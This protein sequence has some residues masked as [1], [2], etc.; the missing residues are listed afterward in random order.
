M[1]QKANSLDQRTFDKLSRLYI[2]ALS[3]IA[4]SVIISQ[5]FVRQHLKKQQ[6]DSTVINVAGRQR[7]L[8][9]KL[10]KEILSL[11]SIENP[12]D[13]EGVKNSLKET[14]ELWQR[15]HEALQTGD[16]KMGLPSKN[17][18]E[19]ISMF[20]GLNVVFKTISEATERIIFK[21]ENSQ[22]YAV[23]VFI[24]DVDLV[25]TNEGKFLSMMDDI[26][27]QYDL[28]AEERVSWLGTLE[29]LL[30]GFTLLVLLGEFLFIFWPTAK[31]VR[32][33][34]FELLKAEKY[35]KKMAFEADALSIAKEKSIKEL[36]ALSQAMDETLL[37][38]RILPSGQI[39]HIGNKFSRRFKFSKFNDTALFWNVMSV[40][41]TERA[42]LESLI[43][44]FKK[45]GWQGEVKATT[46]AEENIWLEMAII[47]Y[48]PTED[49]AEL[50]IIASEITERKAGQ[51]EIERLNKK[52]FQEEISQ[53]KIISS[54]IIENQEKE[55]NR[56][57]K[58]VHDG[59]GQMLTGLKY[60]LESININDIEKTAAKIE[61]L[62]EL[63]TNI[64]K[65]V[66]TATFNLTPPE[67]SDH[68]IVPAITKL[69]K[70]LA[71]LTGKDIVLFNKTNFGGRLDSL[72]EINI[73]RITQEAINNAIKYADSSHILVSLSHSKNILSIVIDDNGKGFDPSKV[74]NVKNADGG[75]G[76]TF[77]NERIKY[78]DGRLFL[79][80]QE[81]K[82]T[83]VTL[84]IP[85]AEA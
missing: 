82:G 25:K 21:A 60:N 39:V 67:L 59:I 37:F 66:R 27:N 50:L 58:D 8:S 73:Y 12:S 6:D 10:T 7:M 18:P 31:S 13:L 74:K 71:R 70:E 55:Q 3:T 81:G 34:L 48:S 49:K 45:T 23:S 44:K 77:M 42:A 43:A 80:S 72:V 32:G 68:G 15:S 11:S 78:I 29:I 41:D 76:M 83:R 4:L 61:H 2:I 19:I 63:T 33:T 20:Q 69:T 38:A 40:V 35:A 30:T 53:Q 5:V 26:V 22:L 54:K 79:S 85:L 51:L 36:R 47:P 9:Q 64:I 24:D 56:I 28:E 65:G 57:A 17:S 16:A 75:M 52:N 14:L 62:K 1:T 46:K 84:N